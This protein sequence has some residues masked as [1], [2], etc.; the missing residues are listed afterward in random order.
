MLSQEESLLE[1][2]Q[3]SHTEMQATKCDIEERL[4]QTTS[5]METLQ[6]GV[7]QAEDM[8]A[9]VN[10][11][12]E[13]AM[14]QAKQANLTLAGERERL[15][16]LRGEHEEMTRDHAAASRRL[17]DAERAKAQDERQN[18]TLVEQLEA[19]R[20]MHLAEVESFNELQKQHDEHV[21]ARDEE[22]RRAVA[23]QDKLEADKLS[24]IADNEHRAELQR[25]AEE[26]SR[27]LDR[28]ERR[29]AELTDETQAERQRRAEHAVNHAE[30][31]ATHDHVSDDHQMEEK[32]SVALMEELEAE[33]HAI[34]EEEDA[35]RELQEECDTLAEESAQHA[36]MH[37]RT[38]AD[39]LRVQEAHNEDALHADEIR[40]ELDIVQPERD[41]LAG[42]RSAEDGAVEK[43]RSDIAEI[44]R[45]KGSLSQILEEQ[46][47]EKE[48]ARIDREKGRNK[49]GQPS[50]PTP[51]S[52]SDV[53]IS[54]AFEG[55]T[56]TLELKPWDTNLEDVVSEWIA[57][58]K[59]KPH[60]KDSI[61]RYLK[62]LE[63]TTHA[64]PVHAE[65]N[66]LEVHEQ[67]AI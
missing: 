36:D 39:L 66:L 22:K 10:S 31:R 25:R 56:V 4:R 32:R 49:E 64:F 18:L 20:R 33:T 40:K 51:L 57:S 30:H 29:V 2:L 67:F 44:V 13:N 62:H 41:R 26:L 5:E 16:Q 21:N 46:R 12:G 59:I 35:L 65:A 48:R 7:S 45:E 9:E 47:Q 63:E 6:E 24:R 38:Q 50:E 58:A 28:H 54:V 17:L 60:L 19:E 43:L 15:Q 34:N 52:V 27:E 1:Q 23:L 3:Q 61:F 11:N 37:A 14:E 53:L 8:H 42:K 55:V